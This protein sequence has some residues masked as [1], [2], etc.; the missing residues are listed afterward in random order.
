MVEKRSLLLLTCT[1]SAGP[2]EFHQKL[3][4][5]SC[6][7]AHWG[8]KLALVRRHGRNGN[9]SE[10]NNWSQN[11][12]VYPLWLPGNRGFWGLRKCHPRGQAVIN[13]VLLFRFGRKQCIHF[14]TTSQTPKHERAPLI[15]LTH[16]IPSLY[17]SLGMLHL[18]K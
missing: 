14:K 15:T 13:V 16:H 2:P 18:I 6:S 7:R 9:D 1:S 11:K 5:Q 12:C 10:R 4:K 8:Q 17:F 3:F